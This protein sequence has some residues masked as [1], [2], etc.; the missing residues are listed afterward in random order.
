MHWFIFLQVY[1]YFI[2]DCV[3]SYMKS[4]P[5]T[6]L[7]SEEKSMQQCVPCVV[8]YTVLLDY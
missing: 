3:K 4:S 5:I 8:N 7:V 6:S 2:K 1:G